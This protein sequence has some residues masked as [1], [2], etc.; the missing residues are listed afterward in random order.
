ML[1]LIS[2]FFSEI[3]NHRRN[4][5]IAVGGLAVFFIGLMFV[6]VKIQ[7]IPDW[8]LRVSAALTGTLIIATMAL[9]G[10]Y[11]VKSI[12]VGVTRT[13]RSVIARGKGEGQ[14]GRDHE[15]LG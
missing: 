12:V 10:Y 8:L 5:F 11:L 6:L 2:Y 7:G 15:N 9:A 14:H 1:E 4:R 13:S 3:W